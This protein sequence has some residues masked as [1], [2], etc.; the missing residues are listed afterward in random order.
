MHSDS[1]PPQQ[2]FGKG[3]IYQPYA[4]V[5]KK[6]SRNYQRRGNGYYANLCLRQNNRD[7]LCGMDQTFY[8]AHFH[9]RLQQGKLSFFCISQHLKCLTP[10]N[11]PAIPLLWTGGHWESP[12]MSC[13]GHG[14]CAR[15]SCLRPSLSLN[16]LLERLMPCT[17]GERAEPSSRL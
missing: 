7:A 13:S 10:Q 14:Y 1:C 4:I 17:R 9:L 2:C 16:T 5:L 6:K 12:P 11:P 8:V 15:G 3:P